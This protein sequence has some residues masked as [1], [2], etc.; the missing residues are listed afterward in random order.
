MRYSKQATVVL[1]ALAMAAFSFAS[2]SS[3]AFH[4][5]AIPLVESVAIDAPSYA[6]VRVVVPDGGGDVSIEVQGDRGP[7]GTMSSSGVWS[8]NPDGS[9]RFAFVFSG[10]AAGQEDLLHVGVPPLGTVVEE[11]RGGSPGFSG[12]ASTA[13]GLAPGEHLFLAIGTTDASSFDGEINVYASEGVEYELTSGDAFLHREQAF[14]G[15]N[16]VVKQPGGPTWLKFIQDASLEQEVEGNLYGLFQGF[17]H[18]NPAPVGGLEMSLDGP[19]TSWSGACTTPSFCA[20]LTFVHNGA[21]GSYTY[22]IDE[23]IEY[24]DGNGFPPVVWAMGA[25]VEL[26]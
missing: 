12:V 7:D 25:D 17:S 16:V 24:F 1:V 6:A 26:P 14:D 2:L 23:N 21:P 15:L 9:P 8:L 4:N 10:F 13:T 19:G 11:K 3:T 18:G 5:P 22:S 20:A